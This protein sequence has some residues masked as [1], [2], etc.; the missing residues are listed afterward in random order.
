MH[1]V[2]LVSDRTS[3]RSPVATQVRLVLHT[4]AYWLMRGLRDAIPA[5]SPLSK[6]EFVTILRLRLLKLGARVVEK[7]GGIRIHFASACPD[8]ALFRMLAARPAPGG[9]LKYAASLPGRA[10]NLQ[11]LT[12]ASTEAEPRRPKRRLR[13]DSSLFQMV[14]HMAV[15]M[16]RSG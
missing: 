10:P 14:R 4:A 8:A 13:A 12:P 7:V 3:C 16:N 2:R 9:A 11:S 5:V 15:R 1:K 6:V